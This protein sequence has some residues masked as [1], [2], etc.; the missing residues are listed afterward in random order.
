MQYVTGERVELVKN[1][2]NFIHR[3]FPAR[4]LG[5]SQRALFRFDDQH[6]IYITSRIFYFES[7]A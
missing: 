2:K 7:A 6:V 1:S 3:F 4:S 5:A